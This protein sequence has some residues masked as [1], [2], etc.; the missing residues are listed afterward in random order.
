MQYYEKPK[1]LY[2]ETVTGEIFEYQAN[3]ILLSKQ[4][5]DQLVLFHKDGTSSTFR[6]EEIKNIKIKQYEP[7][8]TIQL[9]VVI[10]VP[11]LVLTLI[12]SLIGIALSGLG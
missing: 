7:E 4:T 6:I 11:I 3:D 2:I 8:K 5:D 10:M 1:I 9:T 12:I